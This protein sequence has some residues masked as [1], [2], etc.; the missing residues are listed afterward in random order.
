MGQI[1]KIKWNALKTPEK[2]EKPGVNTVN[3]D[4]KIQESFCEKLLMVGWVWFFFPKLL[5]LDY[6]STF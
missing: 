4:T 6:V 3:S 1:R 5:H 2:H